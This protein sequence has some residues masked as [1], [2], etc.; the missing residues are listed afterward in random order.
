MTALLFHPTRRDI[1]LI[2]ILTTLFGLFLQLD[3]SLRFTDSSG[4]NS[5]LGFKV[6]FGGRPSGKGDE[7]WD[8]VGQAYPA[9]KGPKDT[10]DSDWLNNVETGAKAARLAGMDEARVYWGDEGAVRTEVL[11]HAPG[12][13]EWYSLQDASARRIFELIDWKHAGWTIFDQIYLFNGTWFLVTDKPSSI[14]LLRLMTSTG[15]EIWN[16]QESIKGRCVRSTTD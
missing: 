10:S 6:G 14:P 3:F 8:E 15:N 9:A 13:F 1:L 12:M 11:A 4:S 7:D 16:D 5:L 2:L